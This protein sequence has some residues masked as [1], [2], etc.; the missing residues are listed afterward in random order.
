MALAPPLALKLAA[1]VL[2]ALAV[3]H[4]DRGRPPQGRTA[5]AVSRAEGNR[6]VVSRSSTLSLPLGAGIER[7]CARGYSF[8]EHHWVSLGCRL[9][10]GQSPLRS[11]PW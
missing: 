5:V 2:V 11:P 6:W 8:R 1:G 9:K 7:T 3:A 10:R 4:A